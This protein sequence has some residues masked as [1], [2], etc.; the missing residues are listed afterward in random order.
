[1]TPFN[2]GLA[3]GSLTINFCKKKKLIEPCFPNILEKFEYGH[4]HQLL[5]EL[6]KMEIRNETICY[7]KRKRQLLR[8]KEN[9]LQQKTDKLDQEICNSGALNPSLLDSY[10]D[11]KN[12]LKE[13]YDCKGKE[14]IFRSK[15]RWL[16]RVRNQL[17]IFFQFRE[18][19]LRKE[20][21]IAVEGKDGKIISD[22]NLINKEIED[23]FCD[24]LT[25]KLS[26]SQQTEFHDN[27]I[28][29]LVI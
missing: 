21:Y 18:T 5:W 25:S 23:F 13:V 12:E 24:L 17:N 15:M 1:M 14:A 2:A 8:S 20:S 19:K 27:L 3:I 16:K 9:T 7:S 10:E 29:S 11:V 28:L 4:S 6:I 22:L 26:Q